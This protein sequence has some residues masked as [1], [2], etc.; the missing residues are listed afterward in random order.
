[1]IKKSSNLKILKLKGN[2][3]GDKGVKLL[4][5]A[6]LNSSIFSLDL[7]SNKL[8]RDSIQSLTNLALSNI[9]LK[10][11]NLSRNVFNEK[12]KDVFRS[13][14]KKIGIILEI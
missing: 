7:S 13:N 6:L 14:F 12:F 3:I 4:C 9:K 5:K 1:M 8:T 2:K 11:L 10:K